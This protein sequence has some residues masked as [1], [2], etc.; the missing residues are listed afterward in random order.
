MSK[1]TRPPLGMPYAEFIGIMAVLMALTALSIDI[2]LVVLPDIASEFALPQQNHQQHVVT[3][4]MAAFALGHLFMGPLSD[5]FGRRPVLLVGIAIYV[6]GSVI[7]IFSDSFYVLLIARA[8]QGFGAAAPRVIAVAVVRDRFVGRGMSQVMSFVMTVFI[9]L[10]MIAPAIGKLIALMGSWHPI[11][12]FLALVGTGMFIWVLLRLPETNPRNTPDAKPAVSV[13]EAV[14]TI[15]GSGQTVGYTL[16]QGFIFG[17]LMTYI[18]SSQQVLADLYGIVEWFPLVFA[19]VAAAMVVSSLVN[20]RLVQTV[21]M[22]RLSHSALLSLVAL[23]A[24]GSVSLMV[25]GTLPFWVFLTFMGIAFFLIGLIL[26]N[27][28]AMAMEPL[29]AIAGTGSSLVGFVMTACG[30]LLGAAVGQLYDQSLMPI[31]LGY[32]TFSL[33]SLTFVMITEKGRLLQP[34]AQ[35]VG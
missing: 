32:L 16:A 5:R 3:A 34:T 23:S 29:G 17:C 8:I 33:I 4:Y 9:M 13:L 35:P 31:I 12:T 30:A 25:G 21:G 2:V 22:R 27:F 1:P 26:P 11:F 6:V 24:L 7:A 20:A 18:A 19:S 10:P 15:L 14:R 28:N